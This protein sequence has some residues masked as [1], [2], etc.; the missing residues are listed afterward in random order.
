MMN[1]NR[2]LVLGGIEK[3]LSKDKLRYRVE[4]G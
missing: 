4:N 2:E 3:N 1:I